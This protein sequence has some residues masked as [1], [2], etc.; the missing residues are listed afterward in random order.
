MRVEKVAWTRAALPFGMFPFRAVGCARVRSTSAGR[1]REGAGPGSRRVVCFI[2]EETVF[3]IWTIK[4]VTFISKFTHSRDNGDLRAVGSENPPA[5]VRG[6][7]AFLNR[8][9]G[10][11]D[12]KL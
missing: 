8:K 4:G 3:I 12:S 10:A 11:F 2:D 9:S 5:E 1:R 6:W 7:H